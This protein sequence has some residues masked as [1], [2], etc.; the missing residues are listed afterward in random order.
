MRISN[1]FCLCTTEDERVQKDICTLTCTWR[2][3]S[4]TKRNNFST[5][6]SSLHVCSYVHEASARCIARRA[7]EIWS[8]ANGNRTI[9]GHSEPFLSGPFQPRLARSERC[10]LVRSHLRSAYLVSGAGV[11]CLVLGSSRWRM[12]SAGHGPR[13][14]WS[15]ICYVIAYVGARL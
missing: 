15:D 11:R 7:V 9:G 14:D 10:V 5:N 3:L 13:R 2:M 8:M 6:A 1:L 4:R 12:K